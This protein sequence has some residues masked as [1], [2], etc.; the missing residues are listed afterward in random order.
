V[1]LVALGAHVGASAAYNQASFQNPQMKPEIMGYDARPVAGALG[2]ISA[3]VA[4]WWVGALGL[5]LAAASAQ[6]YLTNKQVK[7][8][9]EPQIAKLLAASA[10]PATRPPAPATPRSGSQ[11]TGAIPEWL[12]AL[13]KPA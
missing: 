5:G 1:V 9:L 6:S 8:S 2:L 11:G 4:P 13:R 3:L 12:H 7:E 10:P